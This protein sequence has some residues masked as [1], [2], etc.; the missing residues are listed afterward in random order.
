MKKLRL[1]NE[2]FR[3]LV[4]YFREWLDVLGYAESTV[5]YLPNHLQEFFYHMERHGHTGLNTI[6]GQTVKEYYETLQRRSNERRSGA[7]SKAYLNK[8]QQALKKFRDYL[9]QHGNDR[10]TIHLKAEPNPTEEKTNILVQAE[11]KELFMATGHSHDDEHY[12]LRDKAILTVLY[13]CG[14][15]RNEA[16]HLDVSDVLFDRERLYVRKG[17]NYRERFVP[18]NDY[19]LRVLEDY[20]FEGRPEFT[21]SHMG[22][23][24][25]ISRSGRRLD[26]T[27]IALRLKAIVAA[28]ENRTI[29]AK[30]ITPHTLRHSIAT[31]LLQRGVPLESIKTFLGHASLESTQLYTHLLKTLEHENL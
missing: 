20:I 27:S 21:D 10:F 18:L 6:T 23:A 8:H 1:H 9:R 24:L 16:I 12:R 13:S 31:H 3:K 22:E 11:I 7:L 26:G 15:R 19:N 17:K 30:G 28:S 2:G 25:L 14:L 4:A 5:Y 29:I